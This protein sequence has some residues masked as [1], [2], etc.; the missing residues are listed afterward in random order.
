MCGRYSLDMEARRIELLYDL[1]EPLDDTMPRYNISPSQ[2]VAVIGLKPDGTTRGLA[3][4]QW[5]FVPR[6]A[7][8]PKS[9]PKPINARGETLLDK[10]MFREA[11][12]SRRCIIPASG[13]YEWRTVGRKKHAHY[14]RL[15]GEEPMSFAGIWDIWGSGRERLATCCIITVAAND[16]VAPLHDRMPAILPADAFSDWLGRDT[17]VERAYALLKSYPAAG[18]T[19]DPVGPAV[20]SVTNDSPECIA[21]AS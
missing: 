5:G 6:W 11:F 19:V 3:K 21:P 1:E 2:Q 20:N 18:M 14:I 7:N 9:G 13:F 15:P 8:D 4:L 12:L 10:P 17:P 16:A